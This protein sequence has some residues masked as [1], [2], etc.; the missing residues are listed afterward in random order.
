[1][2]AAINPS[3]I[4]CG[5]GNNG[6]DGYVAAKIL[7]DAGYAVR[8][9]QSHQPRSPLCSR[10]AAQFTNDIL[11]ELCIENPLEHHP[12]LLIDAC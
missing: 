10:A 3:N 2:P 4:C 9:Y 6:G 11:T 12:D 5:G 8:I 1:M 7:Y